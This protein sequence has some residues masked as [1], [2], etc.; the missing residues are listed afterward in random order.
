MYC[1]NIYV[2]L[3][4]YESSLFAMFWTALKNNH[5]Q[6]LFFRKRKNGVLICTTCSGCHLQQAMCSVP[7]CLIPYCTR[8]VAH[9]YLTYITCY[10][11]FCILFKVS[12]L[13]FRAATSTLWRYWKVQFW[14]TQMC[15]LLYSLNLLVCKWSVMDKILYCEDYLGMFISAV[16][17]N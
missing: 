4:V 5:M 9:V 13:H 1:P 2:H 17:W 11:F 8:S 7:V 15:I 12:L 16:F 6:I 14:P 3:T 10:F